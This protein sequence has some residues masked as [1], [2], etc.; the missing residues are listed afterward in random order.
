MLQGTAHRVG[1]HRP[2]LR[3]CTS[4]LKSDNL[5]REKQ[6]GGTEEEFFKLPKAAR[7]QSNPGTKRNEAVRL[8]ENIP[9]APGVLVVP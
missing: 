7:S 9:F 5:L 6:T 8:E 3:P 2:S 4:D 1:A